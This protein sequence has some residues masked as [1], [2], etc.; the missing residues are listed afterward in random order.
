MTKRFDWIPWFVTLAVLT[1][2]LHIPDLSAQSPHS[3]AQSGAQQKASG[4]SKKWPVKVLLPGSEQIRMMLEISQTTIVLNQKNGAA[5]EIPIG[6]V[7]EVTYDNSSHRKNRGLMKAASEIGSTPLVIGVYPLAA[8]L[9][10]AAI[11]APFKTRTH[12]VG[13]PWSD[14]GYGH[15]EVL[16]E[17]GKGD[18]E[19]V[20]AELQSV[21]GKPW[22]NLPEERRKQLK[23]S[24][25][26]EAAK[27][28]VALNSHPPSAN[29][30][31]SSEQIPSAS[32]LDGT[33]TYEADPGPLFLVTQVGKIGYIDRNGRIIIP[34]QYDAAYGFSEGLARIRVGDKWGYIDKSGQMVITPQY[35]YSSGF[36]EELAAV[37]DF[38]GSGHI[39]KVGY[40]D[41]TGQ[42]VISRQYSTTD[43]VIGDAGRFTEGMAPVMVEGRWGYIDKTGEMII[44]PQYS[45]ASGFSEGL[46]A[47]QQADHKWGYVDKEGKIVIPA[48]YNDAFGFSEGLAAIKQANDKWG[49][50]DKT[51]KT[52]IP[53]RYSFS[54]GFSGGLAVV[55]KGHYKSGYIDKTGKMVIPPRYSR[56]EPFSEGLAQ[57]VV[58][59]KAGYIDKTGKML[60]PL[61]FA[62][63]AGGQFS[64]GLAFVQTGDRVGY[65]NKTG[66]YV[67]ARTK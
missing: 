58:G 36:H 44:H 60:I 13:I 29:A 57:V 3:Q 16:L 59:D 56:A 25:P 31:A 67:W 66:K 6:E 23:D 33:D 34:P 38:G 4:K 41:R 30:P 40:I 17:V 2:I 1:L 24:K 26:S 52:V 64:E 53:P 18:Y 32:S 51:G 19:G 20:L 28:S 8:P 65:I 42:I 49:Y 9:V 27:Q 62:D 5:Q 22:R 50:I 21:T 46:A 63:A 35:E 54:R 55:D 12:Y 39:D 48:Q 45:D 7:G 14:P 37:G 10:G 15:R 43:R 47:V 11:L 61:Q